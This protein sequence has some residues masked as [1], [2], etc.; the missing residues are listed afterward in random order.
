[1][2]MVNYFEAIEFCNWIGGQLPKENEWIYA[3]KG[4]N[5]SKNSTFAGANNLNEVGWYKTNSDNHSHPVGEM[6]SNEL[7]INSMCENALEWC[8]NDS[9]KTNSLFC[10]HKGDSWYAGEKP[11]QIEARYG[12]I[13][14]HFSNSVGFRVIF[15]SRYK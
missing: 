3:A 11:A 9:L 12:N 10:V 1:M 15:H 7:G 2:V 8:L 4:G 13:P 6:K 14:T 5:E